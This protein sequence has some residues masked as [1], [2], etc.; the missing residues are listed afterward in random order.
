MAALAAIALPACLVSKLPADSPVYSTLWGQHGELWK[1]EVTLPDFSYAGYHANEAAIPNAPA[2]RDLKR[3]FHAA[4]DAKTDDAAALENAV[5]QGGV[6]FI[7][8]GKYRISRSIQITNGNFVLR[9]AG[10]GKT[11]L[12]FPK[13][14]TDLKGNHPDKSGQSEWS[15]GPGLINISGQDPI[16]ASTRIASVIA[17]ARRGDRQ[18][19]L[20]DAP[21]IHPGEWVRLVESDPPKSSPQTGTLIRYLY[22]GLP[23]DAHDL[24]GETAVVRFP[25]RIVKVNNLNG[26]RIEL[27]RPLPYD[28]NLAWTPEIH[29]FAPTVQEVGIENLSIEFP[30]TPYPGHFREKGY[31]ALSLSK[32]SQCWVRDIEIKNADFGLALAHTNFCTVQ[33]LRL[34][35]S[36]DRA[37]SREARGA[38]GH[39]GIDIGHGAENLVTGFDVET[40]FVHDISLEWYVLHTVY[41][42]GRGL[43]LAMD[44][45]REANY[46]NLFT[47]IDCGKGSRPFYS[48]GNRDRGA[49]AGAY[50]TYW[51][52]RAQ[53]SMSLPPGGFGPLLNFIGF[54]TR[55]KHAPHN[56][57]WF[58][59]PVKPAELSPPDLAAAMRNRRLR[60]GSAGESTGSH[61]N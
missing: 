45:H 7:P 8:E 5:R 58:L 20:S 24:F 18:L 35:V 48:G 15:F 17:P 21:S 42:N 6:I 43:D 37:K 30:W 44:H 41:A 11:V 31:N 59:E 50:N 55:A 27:E 49:Y 47:D 39:H 56:S 4:G 38:S 29:R 33:N 36:A 9:G 2:Q 53:D 19:V 22:A 46:S 10:P 54:E 32:V 61:P 60:G 52:I 12:Y 34:T 23:D 25:S 16:D 26:H 1:P 40:R 57:H 28:V 3:D 51:N 13:S 14:L